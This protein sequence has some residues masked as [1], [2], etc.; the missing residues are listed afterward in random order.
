MHGYENTFSCYKNRFSNAKRLYKG[1]KT[2]FEIHEA[3]ES[4]KFIEFKNTKA[5]KALGNIWILLCF[6]MIGLWLSVSK[7]NMLVLIKAIK[8]DIKNKVWGQDDVIRIIL[9]D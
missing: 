6:F 9:I 7:S 4:Q 8:M 5:H 2:K 3:L 1:H